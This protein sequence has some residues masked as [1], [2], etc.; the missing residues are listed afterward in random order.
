M[1]D[2]TF[3]NAEP[4]REVTEQIY[5]KFK[6]KQEVQ[7]RR[8]Y[9]L[10]FKAQF[11]N[12]LNHLKNQG[13]KLKTVSCL[14]SWIDNNYKELFNKFVQNNPGYNYDNRIK[15]SKGLFMDF[16][17]NDKLAFITNPSLKDQ[18]LS[19]VSKTKEQLL[20]S[21]RER[22]RQ[23]LYTSAE[24]LTQQRRQKIIVS[25]TQELKDQMSVEVNFNDRDVFVDTS[26]ERNIRFLCGVK[27]SQR[28]TQIY[29]YMT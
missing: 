1:D 19:N 13:Q 25:Q 12:Q 8:G 21:E 20:E 6:N 18:I 5:F 27:P 22:F 2:Y 23:Y 29:Q 15:G 4:S 10:H 11:C 17:L 9:C 14:H 16:K 26:I 7:H 24:K 28:R 3:N